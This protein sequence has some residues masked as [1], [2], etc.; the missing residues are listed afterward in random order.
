MQSQT[1]VGTQTN[2]SVTLALCV[3]QFELPRI[4]T[5][6]RALSL[7]GQGCWA[8]GTGEFPQ[9]CYSCPRT[10]KNPAIG[11]DVSRYLRQ[12]RHVLLKHQAHMAFMNIFD[13]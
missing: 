2:G 11:E 6:L 9:I 4:P 7:G 1:L 8:C 3:R 5:H 10:W 12:K 13:K